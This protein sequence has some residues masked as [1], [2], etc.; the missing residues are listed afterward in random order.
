MGKLERQRGADFEREMAQALS[1]LF[2]LPIGR[3]LGQERDGGTDIHAPGLRIECKRRR[4]FVGYTWFS[5]ADLAASKAPTGTTP[6]PLVF[7]RADAQPPMALLPAGD[8]LAV[9]DQVF[10]LR[11]AL[12]AAGLP[13]PA[14]RFTPSEEPDPTQLALEKLL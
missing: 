10:V 2:G 7:V 6:L 8:L 4:S 5:Q 12:A 14:G 11:A 3:Q 13:V 9:L 1:K